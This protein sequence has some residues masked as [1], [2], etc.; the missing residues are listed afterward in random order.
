MLLCLGNSVFA[1]DNAEHGF[2]FMVA[3]APMKMNN[4]R[5]REWRKQDFKRYIR[6]LGSKDKFT[7]SRAV[8]TIIRDY[9][10]FVPKDIAP[11]LGSK[12]P[13]ERH[14]AVAIVST[15]PD[16]R[17][18]PALLKI[19]RSD[20]QKTIR[21][22]AIKAL[23]SY[24]APDVGNALIE[25]YGERS[26]E[27]KKMILGIFGKNRFEPALPLIEKA[28]EDEQW[29]VREA[30]V[31]ALSRF[32]QPKYLD[33]FVRMYDDADKHVRYMVL[34]AIQK[35]NIPSNQKLINLL[36]R[37]AKDK[38]IRVSQLAAKMLRFDRMH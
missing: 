15:Y 19:V 38:D 25:V 23:G 9:K 21:K 27:E 32:K 17:Y 20:S 33:V 37:A 11:L 14:S 24:R 16:E 10:D 2:Q 6:Q 3:Q 5:F 13:I 7:R 36:N 31:F 28:L 34:K 4:K 26:A 18:K 30:A 1:L 35:Y 8:K 22:A 12:N 29:F